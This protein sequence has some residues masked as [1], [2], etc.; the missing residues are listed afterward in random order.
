MQ[1]LTTLRAIVVSSLL[2]GSAV[3]CTS[4]EDSSTDSTAAELDGRQFILQFADGYTPVSGSVIRLTFGESTA[5]I[6]ADCNTVT[7]TYQINDH[8]LALSDASVTEMGCDEALMDQDEWLRTFFDSDP[9]ITLHGDTL[10][11]ESKGIVLVFVDRETADPDRPLVGPKWTI[12]TLITADTAS[13]V[14]AL[15]QPPTL[16]FSDDGSFTVMTD[17]NSGHGSYDSTAMALTFAD[18]TF[19]ESTC[20][21]SESSTLSNHLS[22]VF[23]DGPAVYSIEAARLKIERED[24]GIAAAADE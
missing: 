22:A 24:I 14:P 11:L 10:T 20:T 4:S 16:S 7:G 2:I 9:D 21:D 13:T 15:G 5:R 17:C 18:V 6:N 23:A 8:K 3:A 1:M 19:T 12:D